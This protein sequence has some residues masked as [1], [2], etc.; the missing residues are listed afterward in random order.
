MS[1]LRGRE[2][3]KR[4]SILLLWAATLCAMPGAWPAEAAMSVEIPAGKFKAVRMRN[5]P[6]DAV[7]AVVVEASGPVVVSLLNEQDAR[8]F[9]KADEPVFI[10]SL[11]RRLSFTITIPADGTYFLV[12]DNRQGADARKV[13][14]AIRAQRGAAPKPP[15]SSLPPNPEGKPDKL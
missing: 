7:M 1:R 8:H 15:P 3:V 2:A 6:K 11:D 10:G 9:P 13:K 5:L 14:F 12:L 4:L